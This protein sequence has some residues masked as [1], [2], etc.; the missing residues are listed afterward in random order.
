MSN[1]GADLRRLR[2][3][4]SLSQRQLSKMSGVAYPHICNI[5]NG[6]RDASFGTLK[7]IFQSMGF[8]IDLIVKA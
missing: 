4:K 7:K 1:I 2:E 5:E 6:K 8:D 3:S